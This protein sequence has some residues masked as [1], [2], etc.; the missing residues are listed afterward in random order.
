[1]FYEILEFFRNHLFFERTPSRVMLGMLLVGLFVF[2]VGL[3]VYR[4]TKRLDKAIAFVLFGGVIAI[5]SGTVFFVTAVNDLQNPIPESFVLKSE[6]KDVIVSITGSSDRNYILHPNTTFRVQANRL[7]A[8]F[9]FDFELMKVE[10]TQIDINDVQVVFAV[11]TTS[12]NVTK[13]SVTPGRDIGFR[14][15]DG[16][17]AYA[18]AWSEARG[19]SKTKLY[20]HDIHT[21][22]FWYGRY[23]A[24]ECPI[25][26]PCMLLLVYA[27]GMH[28][29]SIPVSARNLQMRRSEFAT[30]FVD[31]TVSS[32]ETNF[33]PRVKFDEIQPLAKQKFPK[34]SKM[35][36]VLTFMISLA[37]SYFALYLAFIHFA[38]FFTKDHSSPPR[39]G[40]AKHK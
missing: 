30:S 23:E 36:H 26:S 35:S 37:L 16:P 22:A 15:D 14:F 32:Q 1:M 31:I 29:A 27:D 18:V 25:S 10:S 9:M 19:T 3:F 21:L 12:G 28:R 7:V 11:H 33:L 38:D 4:T 40:N 5:I 39:R 17:L 34:I 6:Q 24:M 8:G 2:F 13:I 20:R